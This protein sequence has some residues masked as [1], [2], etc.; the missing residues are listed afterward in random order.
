M[1]TQLFT[2]DLFLTKTD[3]LQWAEEFLFS[4]HDMDD[5]R[6][7]LNIYLYY[8]AD[9]ETPTKGP[10]KRFWPVSAPVDI[11]WV[12]N[13]EWG[14]EAGNMLALGK[15]ISLGVLSARLIE[16]DSVRNSRVRTLCQASCKAQPL[17]YR[18]SG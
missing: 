17:R 10:R 1:S 6:K 15:L 7:I 18:L 14:S 8:P 4:L 11:P 3:D 16:Y 12:L 5:E 9:S 13:K 2:L